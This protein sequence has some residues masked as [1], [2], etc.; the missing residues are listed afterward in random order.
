MVFSL[1]P[2]NLGFRETGSSPTERGS[3]LLCRQ[4]DGKKLRQFFSIC[5]PSPWKPG[6][7]EG[8]GRRQLL[9]GC[10]QSLPL[11]FSIKYGSPGNSASQNSFIRTFIWHPVCTRFYTKCFR[12][13]TLKTSHKV[14]TAIFIL[15]ETEAHRW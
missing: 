3:S 10:G 4:A 15:E 12:S 2:I 11:F 6:E 8:G 13:I 9:Q 14:G 5:Y 7:E 1:L